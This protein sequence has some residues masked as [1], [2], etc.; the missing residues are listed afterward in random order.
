MRKACAILGFLLFGLLAPRMFGQI[1]QQPGASGSND[2]LARHVEGADLEYASTT[3]AFSKALFQAGA[4]GGIARTSG[5]EWDGVIHRWQPLGSSL[6]DVLDGIVKTDPQYRWSVED[7]VINV[8]PVAGEPALLKTHIAEFKVENVAWASSALSKLIAM[9]E[10]R[11]SLNRLGLNETL[12]AGVFPAP[13]PMKAGRIVQCNN[14]TL[15]EALNVIA[16]V[17]GNAVWFYK[18]DHCTGK[19]E[20]SIDFI[21]E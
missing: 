9:P 11:A 10:V 2:V 20:Y 7:E 6:R 13:N 15:R 17:F 5:C 14:V 4:P 1:G 21:V 12:K 8:L 19:D 3:Q 18:E 16:R